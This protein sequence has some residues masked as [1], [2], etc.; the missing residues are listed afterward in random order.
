MIEVKDEILNGEPEYRLKDKNGNIIY[1]NLSIEMITEILQAGTPLNKVLFDRIISYLVPSGFIGMWS[2]SVIPDGWYLCDGS[3]DTPDLRDRFIV[4]SGGEY[5]VGN[6][7]GTN[8]VTLTVNQIPSHR[9]DIYTTC[10]GGSN[11]EKDVIEA[12][13]STENDSTILKSSWRSDST[14][15]GQ[16][17]ENRPPYYALA[18]IMKA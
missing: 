17:H 1:D 16:P 3:N 7:G 4:G 18:F 15:G 12:W 2:G 11:V 6:T 8:A 14:G 5:D 10:P 9:H 13:E